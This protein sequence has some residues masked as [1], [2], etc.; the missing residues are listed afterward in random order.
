M[1]SSSSKRTEDMNHP[2]DPR[3][4]H[5]TAPAAGTVIARGVKVEGEFASQGDVVIEGEVHGKIAAAGTLTVGPEAIIKADVTADEASISGFIEGNV[6]VKKQAV[7][8]ATAR[9]KGDLTAERVTIEAGAALDGRVQIGQVGKPDAKP[10]P[11]KP[12][13]P[14]KTE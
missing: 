14:G 11:A 7:L 5:P 12:N 6:N 3:S 9:I 2:I 4:N 13:T 10:T 8:R 1:F